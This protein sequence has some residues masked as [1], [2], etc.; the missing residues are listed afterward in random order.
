MLKIFIVIDFKI[1]MTILNMHWDERD[2]TDAQCQKI[3]FILEHLLL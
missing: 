2:E 3:S 1:K